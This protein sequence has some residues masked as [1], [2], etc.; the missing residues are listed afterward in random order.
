MNFT[1]TKLSV[2]E[3]DPALVVAVRL[4]IAA[5]VL[6]VIM[7]I[8]GHRFPPW[9]PIW[10]A[11]AASAIFGHTL[12]FSLLAWAQQSIDAGL[13]AILMAT[14]PLFTLLLAQLFVRD[15]KPTIYS[16][17]G[18]TLALV[19][20]ILLFGVDKLASLA[21]QSLRQ[22]AAVAAALCYGVNAIVTKWL[23]G[24]PWQSTAAGF[25]ALA[26]LFGLPNLLGLNWSAVSTSPAAWLPVLYSGFMATALAAVM[27]V[28]IV[29]RS[30][31]SFLSQINFIIPV[32]GVAFS[33][34]L[35]NESLPA[36]GALALII[37][38]TGVALARPR[39]NRTVRSVNKG[40]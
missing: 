5:A 9:G 24:L 37:I 17:G 29:R 6:L 40:T 4:A 21:D 31:A 1:M 2:A 22:Y 13:A 14:M 11:L 18:F 7:V 30:G 25:M 39:P 20:I 36:N 8:S 27:I 28:V 26:F 35:V 16:I 33:I 3:L 23:T 32:M 15:E 38:L 19:G 10:W 12:P 34:L